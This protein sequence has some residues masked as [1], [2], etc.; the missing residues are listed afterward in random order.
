MIGGMANLHVR[1]EST[2]K[3]RRSDHQILFHMY[4]AYFS[5]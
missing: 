2:L 5:R 3:G 1:K 4:N